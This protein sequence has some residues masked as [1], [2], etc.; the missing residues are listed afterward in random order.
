MT[1]T[2]RDE[3]IITLRCKKTR[4]KSKEKK[5]RRRIE[6]FNRDSMTARGQK[7]PNNK[8][9]GRSNKIGR[10]RTSP[11]TKSDKWKDISDKRKTKPDK[12]E[13]E[14]LFTKR[15]P[16]AGVRTH[17]TNLFLQALVACF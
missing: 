17:Q 16:D 4:A 6:D 14:K 8:N 10:F 11:E 5:H 13:T 3:D 2:W 7:K 15:D 12:P 1:N 9:N